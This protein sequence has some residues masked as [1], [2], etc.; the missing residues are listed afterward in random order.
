MLTL[1]ACTLLFCG[2]SLLAALPLTAS[3]APPVKHTLPSTVTVKLGGMHPR[4]VRM[5]RQ[6][7]EA[8]SR[9]AE[10]RTRQSI[11]AAN[12]RRR[13]QRLRGRQ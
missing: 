13:V 9:E 12:A 7:Y 1:R 11:A 10:A 3:G 8:I 6:R 4:T 5:T 2:L